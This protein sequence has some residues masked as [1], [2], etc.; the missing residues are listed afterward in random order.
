MKLT[1]EYAR[2]HWVSQKLHGYP[3]PSEIKHRWRLMKIEVRI[4]Y[5]NIRH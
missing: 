4:W 1:P 2:K 3:I 5:E